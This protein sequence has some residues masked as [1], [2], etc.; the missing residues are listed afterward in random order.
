MTTIDHI[1]QPNHPVG[2]RLLVAWLIRDTSQRQQS[3]GTIVQV[4][5]THWIEND[6]V[7]EIEVME[8]SPSGD[9]VRVASPGKDNYMHGPTAGWYPTARIIVKEAL[10]PRS[11]P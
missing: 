5:E 6:Q 3:Y 2:S 1:N 9:H 7:S 10:M 4:S 8:Y 11:K